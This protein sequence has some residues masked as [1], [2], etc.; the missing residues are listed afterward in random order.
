MLIPQRL[1]LLDGL[2]R[3]GKSALPPI[4]ESFEGMEQI[5]YWNTFERLMATRTLGLIDAQTLRALT[6]VDLNERLYDLR[7]ARN[8][9]FRPEDQTG[10]VRHYDAAVYHARLVEPEGDSVISSISREGRTVP[11]MLHE[12]TSQAKSLM[13]SGLPGAV[14][15]VVRDPIDTAVS[16][17]HRGWGTRFETDLR[18]FTLRFPRGETYVPWYAVGRETDWLSLPQADRCASVVCDLFDRA[19]NGRRLLQD[20]I[21]TSRFE[22]WCSRPSLEFE[23]LK[24]H[25]G[26]QPRRDP[27]I[28][29]AQSGF[30]RVIADD[31]Q[32]EKRDAFLQSLQATQ[33]LELE[34][35]SKRYHD[36][37][38]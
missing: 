28:G 6:E 30:P 17:F 27:I 1:V 20:R 22:N 3:A 35:R 12:A 10:V 19:S 16:W 33:R 32:M 21:L 8:T 7:L 37:A 29:F 34:E 36:A 15:E 9:N 23:R 26:L 31:R 38:V 4:L 5:Q 18:A 2:S 25:I 24:D 14:I 13:E 11:F